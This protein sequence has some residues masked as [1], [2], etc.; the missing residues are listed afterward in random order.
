MST[1]KMREE[2]RRVVGIDWL[3]GAEVC[4]IW[5]LAWKASRL[6]IEV[7][8]PTPKEVC[9]PDGSYMEYFEPEQIDRYIESLGLKVIQC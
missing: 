8:L 4:K 2:F 6:T 5:H 3:E 9:G 1:E 7:V